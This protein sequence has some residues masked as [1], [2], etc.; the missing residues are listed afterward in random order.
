MRTRGAESPPGT[1]VGVSA[2]A[3]RSGRIAGRNAST[4][5]RGAHSTSLAA[6]SRDGFGWRSPH[7]LVG[8]L[9][10]GLIALGWTSIDEFD[11]SP[12]SSFGY[13]LGII[14]L[15]MMVLLL[16]YSVRKRVPAL[17]QLG[18]LRNWFELHLVLG[19]L[20]PTVIL[21]HA[22]FQVESANAA[23]S[24]GCVLVV[25]GSGIGG[26]F[27][28]GRLYRGLAGEPRSADGLKRQA[29]EAIASVQSQL[30]RA[31]EIAS[32]I[33]RFEDRSAG[34]TSGLL[35]A[36]PAL[37]LRPKARLL[38][39]RA[40]RALRPSGLTASELRRVDAAIANCLEQLC[41]A[42]ELRLFSQLFALW[43]A[44]H[45]PLTVIL[46]L[47]AIIHVVAVHLY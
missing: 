9:S 12:A 4:T 45:I 38:R 34:L 13:G 20:A 37:A 22:N 33:A 8:L 24:L 31:P 36:L 26:R 25:A 39:R 23:I 19:M 16:A 43:H 17:R 46:F 27:L 15:G 42:S 6:R 21:Y 29:R 28:Y 10:A 44:I 41:R 1:V 7:A 32:L 3:G 11:L 30:D 14:G 5:T 18:A 40:N 2:G 47:S 35:Y